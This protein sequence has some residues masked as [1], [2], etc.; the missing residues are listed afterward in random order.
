MDGSSGVNA[1]LIRMF[2]YCENP[3]I[4]EKIIV[5]PDPAKS[6]AMQMAEAEN[7]PRR[8]ICVLEYEREREGAYRWWIQLP[9][10]ETLLRI[11]TE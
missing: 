8:V 9:A 5:R 1:L 6:T 11:L 2:G 10:R 4:A 3:F 7:S